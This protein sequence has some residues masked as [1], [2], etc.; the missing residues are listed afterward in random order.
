MSD[1]CGGSVNLARGFPPGQHMGLWVGEVGLGVFRKRGGLSGGGGGGGGGGVT[2]C[3]GWIG[4]RLSWG[5][6]K[7]SPEFF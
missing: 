1:G 3:W 6:L 5:A 7:F 4:V 2:R